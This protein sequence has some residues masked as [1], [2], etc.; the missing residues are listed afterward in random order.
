[1]K[2]LISKIC[3]VTLAVLSVTGCGSKAAKQQETI[4]IATLKGPT[5]MG[6]VQMMEEDAGKYNISIYES[7]DE[8][9]SKVIS[10]EV[11]VAC[12]PSNMGAVLYNKTN[13]GIRLLGVNTL[14]VLYIVENGE[15][16]QSFDDLKG[17]TIVASGKGGT[18]QYVLE[19][20]LQAEGLNPETDVTINY[21]SSHADVM[22]QLVANPGTIALLPQPNVTIAETKSETVHTAIDLN[23]EWRLDKGASLPMGIIIA[24][25]DFVDNKADALSTFLDEY[26]KS[27]DFVNGSSEEAAELMEKHEIIASKAVALKAIPFCNI[28]FEQGDNAQSL[29]D[30]FYSVLNEFSSDAVGGSLPDEAFYYKK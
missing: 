10:K 11:D 28:V 5:G 20:L 24:Q 25:S 22:A 18:P 1:M 3:V 30:P 23:E 6:M 16:V 27:V 26:S 14:G 17:K 12:V 9:V 4:N 8:I 19:S 7:P 29:L 13:Q 21:L 2:S 15:E